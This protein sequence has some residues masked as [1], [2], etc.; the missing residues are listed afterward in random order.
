MLKDLSLEDAERLSAIYNSCFEEKWSKQSF[1]KML[2]NPAYFGYKFTNETQEICG[3]ILCQ[4]VIDEI[5]IITFCVL[6][7]FRKRG[8]GKSLLQAISARAKSLQCS[9]FLEVAT[10]NIVAQNMYIAEG[11]QKIG[12]RKNYYHD[13][14]AIVMKLSC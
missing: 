14:D 7:S 10:N 4:L 11:Y 12:I 1:L 9:V 3:F 2:S 5:E 6:N 8:V 13:I